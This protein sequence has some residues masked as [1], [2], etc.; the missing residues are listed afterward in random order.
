MNAEMHLRFMPARFVQSHAMNVQMQKLFWLFNFFYVL[1]FF[2]VGTV[3]CL[4]VQS[5]EFIKANTWSFVGETLTW[6]FVSAL[7]MLLYFVTRRKTHK[8]STKKYIVQ[9]LFAALQLGLANVILEIGGV[10]DYFLA[11]YASKTPSTD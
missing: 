7:P 1:V 6:T 8:I 2:V 3:F 9:F 4:L 10:W 11:K 5:T